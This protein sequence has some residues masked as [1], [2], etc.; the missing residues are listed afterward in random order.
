MQKNNFFF[1]LNTFILE[2]FSFKIIATVTA[3]CQPQ[4]AITLSKILLVK[5]QHKCVVIIQIE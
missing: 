3:V 4:G 1:T 5:C 2:M